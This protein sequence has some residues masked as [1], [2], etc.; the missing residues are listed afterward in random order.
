VTIR[1]YR[2]ADRGFYAECLEALQDHL[3]AL[4]PFRVVRRGPGYGAKYVA[5]A[6]RTVASNRGS[7]LIAEQDG[8]P[9]GFVASYVRPR[10]PIRELELRPRR[11]G[12]IMDLYVVPEARGRGVGTA[13]L[14]AARRRLVRA[15][16]THLWLDVFVPNR[17]AHALYRRL[18]FRDFG[19]LMMVEAGRLGRGGATVPARG[20]ATR[21]GDRRLRSSRGSRG[22][23]V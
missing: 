22:A 6:R 21:G 16:C 4:D 8:E 15:G 23:S 2:P 1:P 13:L 20:S 14:R 7:V 17:R 10:N 3:V 19:V 12:F 11:Q 9:V 5:F 18:G